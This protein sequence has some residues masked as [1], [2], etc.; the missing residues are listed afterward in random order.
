MATFPILGYVTEGDGYEPIIQPPGLVYT[1]AFIFC[2]QCGAAIS[3]S[4]GPSL[5]AVC[6]PCYE[7][8]RGNRDSR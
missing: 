7:K 2:K 6:V 1:G 8:E 4:G 5:N 3:G